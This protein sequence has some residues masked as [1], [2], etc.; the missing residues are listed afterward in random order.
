MAQSDEK[1]EIAGI[2]PK[3]VM[4]KARDFASENLI[5]C[6]EVVEWR[7]TSL[8]CDGKV[9][10]LASLFNELGDVDSLGMAEGIV[11]KLAS[12]KVAFNS[13]V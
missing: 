9:R 6:A 12:R 1:S 2:D 3:K 5:E 11:V 10:Q 7:D 8:L 13:P 4:A